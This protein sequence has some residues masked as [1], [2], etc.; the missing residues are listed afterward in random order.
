MRGIFPQKED[1]PSL[2]SADIIPT[3][4]LPFALQ[5]HGELKLRVLVQFIIKVRSPV[6]LIPDKFLL[7]FRDLKGNN[8]SHSRDNIKLSKNRF[9][10]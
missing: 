2:K 5:Y 1:V 8:F 3:K 10:I 6:F 7:G 9:K 4:Q